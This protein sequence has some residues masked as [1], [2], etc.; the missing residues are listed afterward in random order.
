MRMQF[1][2]AGVSSF[3]G[4]ARSHHSEAKF[5]SVRGGACASSIVSNTAIQRLPLVGE[6]VLIRSDDG[7]G[8]GF[9]V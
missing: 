3:S 2:F 1:R 4:P 8:L 6:H 5:P 9:R 7:N